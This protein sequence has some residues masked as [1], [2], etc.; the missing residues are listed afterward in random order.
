MEKYMEQI[1]NADSLSE[2]NNIVEKAAFDDELET[3]DYCKV[4]KNALEK[5]H[6]WLPN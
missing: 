3:I 5:A 4:Y 1:A 2:L 6:E